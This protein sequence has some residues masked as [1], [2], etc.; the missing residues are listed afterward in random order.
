MTGIAASLDV[1]PL[2]K[3]HYCCLGTENTDL[4]LNLE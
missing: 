4:E 3:S 2:K 1:D